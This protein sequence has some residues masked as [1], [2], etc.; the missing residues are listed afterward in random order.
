MKILFCLAMIALPAGV[1]AQGVATI[2]DPL[3]P[4]I[5][6]YAHPANVRGE[7]FHDPIVSS[8][9]EAR[10][11]MVQERRRLRRE[12]RFGANRKPVYWR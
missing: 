12:A 9:R 8:R 10:R 2:N 3:A 1:S 11:R 7:S 4:P 6:F 5:K